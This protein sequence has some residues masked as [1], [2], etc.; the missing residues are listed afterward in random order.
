MPF[1]R[2]DAEYLRHKAMQFRALADIETPV[3]RKLREIAAEM[4]AYAAEIDTRLEPHSA[5]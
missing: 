3:S 4:E 2:Q 5:H 1:R